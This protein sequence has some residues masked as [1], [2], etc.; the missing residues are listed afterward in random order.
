[1][2]QSVE[3]SVL[4]Q[5]CALSLSLITKKVSENFCSFPGKF[6]LSA[7]WSE[8]E[9]GQILKSFWFKRISESFSS[10]PEKV[11]LCAKLAEE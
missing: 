10:F 4:F 2:W 1:M 5:T 6:I 8:N 9:F 7:N 3:I 11:I